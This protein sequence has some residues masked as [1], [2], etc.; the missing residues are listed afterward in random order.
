MKRGAVYFGIVVVVIALVVVL[1]HVLR[2][3]RSERELAGEESKGIAVTTIPL[4]EPSP[5]DTISVTGTIHGQREAQVSAETGGRVIALYGEVG[6]FFSEAQAILQLDSS[7]KS[8]AAQQARIAFDKAEADL[9]RARNLFAAKSISDSELEGARLG[10]KSAETVWRMAQEV[11][12][13]TTIR[14]PFAGTLTRRSVEVG[15]TVAPGMPVASLVDLRQVKAEFELTERELVAT[16]E[17]DSV[18][19]MIDVLPDITLRGTITARSLQAKA[20]TRTFP[21]EA[22]FS[23]ASGIASGMFMRG[24]IIVE[25]KGKGFLVHR[26]ALHGAGEQ[27]HVFVVENG[28]AH[29]RRVHSETP[30]GGWVVIYGDKLKPG[31]ALIVTA[32]KAIEGGAAVT[33]SGEGDE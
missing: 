19:A 26:E 9:V 33:V 1:S 5:I 7:V 2:S 16:A 4:R 14:A 17:G 6:D 13:N 22:T 8:L 3:A 15:E 29:D 24:F 27:S 32:S 30:R 28:V 18:L 21:V 11:Y 31:D 12:S 20:G 10:A 23:G 25:G